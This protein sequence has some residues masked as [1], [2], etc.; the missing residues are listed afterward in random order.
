MIYYF[1]FGFVFFI[2]NLIYHQAFSIKFIF[3]GLFF[4][5]VFYPIIFVLNFKKY[6]IFKKTLKPFSSFKLMV[7]SDLYF[8]DSKLNENE[9]KTFNSPNINEESPF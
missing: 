4:Y 7:F 9:K 3:I 5:P 2:S 8:K 6:L 1:L